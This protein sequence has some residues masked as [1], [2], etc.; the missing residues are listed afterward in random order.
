MAK[1]EVNSN[2][3][4]DDQ[5]LEFDFIRASGPGGQNVNK[6]ATAAQLRFDVRNSPSLPE[7]IKARLIKLAG[8][9]V[10]EDGILIIHAKRYRNQ[11]QNR[12]DALNRLIVLIQKAAQPPGVRK[13]TR[14]TV[15]SRAARK[16]AKQRRAEIKRLRRYDPDEW[17]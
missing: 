5:E 17:E 13:P 10:T 7:D 14:P 15:T 9:R 12:L 16:A 11:E 2:L 6:V 1:I 3:S 4:I 8:C